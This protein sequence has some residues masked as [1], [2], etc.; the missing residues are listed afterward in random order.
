MSPGSIDITMCF[1]YIDDAPAFS[2][3]GVR[4]YVTEL[5]PIFLSKP[6]ERA[7]R[8][9]QLELDICMFFS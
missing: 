2:V 4:S 7:K 9:G 5:Y 6:K 3:L 1:F 8:F